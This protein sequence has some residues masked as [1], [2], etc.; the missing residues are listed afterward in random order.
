MAEL[1]TDEQI[2]DALTR[3]PDW[4][5]EGDALVRTAELRSFPAAIEVVR[6]V[7]DCP[8]GRVTFGVMVRASLAAGS[9]YALAAVSGAPM[10]K[11]SRR[12]TGRAVAAWLFSRR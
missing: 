5:R 1:W 11:Q 7:A 12:P 8:S 10:L 6:A 2:N 4:R 9:P 3:L